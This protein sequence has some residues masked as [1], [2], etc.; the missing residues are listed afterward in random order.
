M[1]SPMIAVSLAL[2]AIAAALLVVRRHRTAILAVTTALVGL[3]ALLAVAYLLA[4]RLTGNGIDESVRFHLE[5]PMEGAGYAD[6]RGTIAW[7]AAGL[8]AALAIAAALPILSRRRARRATAPFLA[9]L[10][11]AGLALALDPG[12]R[13]LWRTFVGPLG[14]DSDFALYYQ[15]PRIAPAGRPQNL[16]FVYA[17]SLERTYFDEKLF[18]GLIRGLRRIEAESTTFTDIRPIPGAGWTI[19]GMV[20][21]QCGIPLSGRAGNA[22]TG[23]DTFLP[24]AVCLGEL[25][26]GQGY[27]VEYVGGASLEFAGKGA[28]YRTQGFD[29]VLGREQLRRRLP[30][31]AKLSAWGL[32]DDDLFA[33]AYAELERL[34]R[35]PRPYA[36]FLLTVDTHH[37]EGHVSP[38]V[39]AV[40]YGDGG[41]PMLNAVAAS[42][43]LISGFVDKVRAAA[44]GSR[45]VVVVASDHL[46]MPNTAKGLLDRGDRK[47]LFVIADPAAK[48]GRRVARAGSALDEGP[49]L[50][51]FLGFEGRLGLGRDLMSARTAGG[52]V[53]R[54]EARLREGGWRRDLEAFWDFPVVERE[55]RIAPRRR[56]LTIDAREFSLPCAVEIDPGLHT[57]LRFKSGKRSKNESLADNA[58][59][60]APGSVYLVV[61]KGAALKG[62]VPGADPRRWYAVTGTSP[63]S[64]EARIVDGELAIPVSEIRQ[65]LAAAAAPRP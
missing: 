42:D 26:K 20:A 46:A 48:G 50:L 17:E 10:P 31:G 29:A 57:T 39:A 6:F 36:L 5:A 62:L 13:D 51:P 16:V 11:I 41:N 3:N 65:R 25:L 7:T 24:G 22:M 34:A 47:N 53:Q 33:L 60:V 2:S 32:Y 9:A 59:R 4:D 35:D 44:W 40:R 12:A 56:K 49:T 37:P 55:I 52:E 23:M 43:A 14:A 1:T 45:A 58:K 28:F 63:G 38:S 54:I 61:D 19:A 15:P 21:S 8:V 30:R 18:P 27:R 64:P